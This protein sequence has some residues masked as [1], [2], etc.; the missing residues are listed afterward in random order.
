MPT[1]MRM[2]LI[3]SECQRGV[4]E[5]GTGHFAGL[6]DEVEG[7]GIV[8][9]IA[10]LAAA[11]RDAGQPV[12]HVPVSHRA[13]FADVQAN[14]LLGAMAR[15]HKR[16]VA[17]SGE[18]AF[19][20]ALQPLP[21][22]IIVDRTSGLIAFHGTALDA[23]LRRMGIGHI[24]LTGVS[25]NVAIAGCAM[26]AADLGYHVRVAEDCIAGSDPETHATIV[27]EQLRMVARVVSAAEVVASLLDT[28][29]S[30]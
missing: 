22:D 27:R 30:D 5:R 1:D 14:T 23:I 3:I 20:S 8:P 24:V 4:I 26:A 19:V 21:G 13:D 11:F 2:A 15:K 12:I 7:R 29:R 18:A 17:G 10:G 25:T 6:I 9:R 16:M 28:D